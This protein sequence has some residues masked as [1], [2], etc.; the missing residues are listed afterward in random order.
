MRATAQEATRR[1]L[2]Q[3]ADPE[4]RIKL[5]KVTNAAVQM[6]AYSVGTTTELAKE[7]LANEGEKGR[8]AA[9]RDPAR[10]G[11]TEDEKQA[12]S[13]AV[14]RPRSGHPRRRR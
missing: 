12:Q 3:A 11:L 8:A 14:R 6:D 7:L 10:R 4:H 5:R 9:Q 1:V 2:P 13:T